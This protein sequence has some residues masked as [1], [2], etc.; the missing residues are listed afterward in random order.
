[1]P[2]GALAGH[3]HDDSRGICGVNGGLIVDGAAL[4]DYCCYAVLSC[5][6][7]AILEGEEGV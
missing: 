5:K 2:E 1:M 7:N 3:H 4:L 6:L